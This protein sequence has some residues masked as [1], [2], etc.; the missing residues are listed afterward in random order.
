MDTASFGAVSGC[1]DFLASMEQA[2]ENLRACADSDSGAGDAGPGLA[3]G[4]ALGG[5]LLVAVLA[6]AIFVW[7][8]K[9]RMQPPPGSSSTRG[10]RQ[11]EVEVTV[12]RPESQKI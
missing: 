5:C 9:H 6:T 7:R 4:L 10:P 12:A 8:R 11:V 2:C 1:P 3:I